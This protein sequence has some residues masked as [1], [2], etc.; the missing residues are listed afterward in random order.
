[1]PLEKHRTPVDQPAPALEQLHRAGQHRAVVVAGALQQRVLVRQLTVVHAQ[2]ALVAVQRVDVGDHI[3]RGQGDMPDVRH[4]GDGLAGH[5]VKML[6]ADFA[7]GA[8]QLGNA[9]GLTERRAQLRFD[10]GAHTGQA[11][12]G[13]GDHFGFLALHVQTPEHHRQAD[14]DQGKTYRQQAIEGGA[15]VLW[16]DQ[17]VIKG[18]GSCAHRS[19]IRIGLLL[20]R[21]LGRNVERG[22]LFLAP[23][24]YAR[25][26]T[27]HPLQKKRC[28]AHGP[29]AR[30]AVSHR[31]RDPR[32]VPPG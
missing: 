23:W 32:G 9:L 28:C 29:S 1:M 21:R 27:F 17:I 11:R 16:Q 26:E 2:H 24:R 12:A 6:G 20:Y 14:T 5:V 31:Q 25:T 8:Q 13:I 3:A 7:V 18:E 4:R 19:V 15:Q 30:F 22:W 10:T